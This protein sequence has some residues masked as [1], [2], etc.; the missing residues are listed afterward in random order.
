MHHS[1]N[2]VRVILCNRLSGY[3]FVAS[4]LVAILSPGEPGD[5]VL[6]LGVDVAVVGCGAVGS[7]IALAL[8]RAGLRVLVVTRRKAS[9]DKIVVEG[10]GSGSVPIAGWG[11]A[12]RFRPR[13]VLYAVKAYDLRGAV[14]N[15]VGAGWSPAAVVSLQNGLGSLE[16]L[17]EVFPGR[18]LLGIVYF[19][20]TLVAPC[21]ARLAGRGSVLLGWRREP[22][23]EAGKAC[24]FL[25]EALGA[26]GLESYCVGAEAERYRWLKLAVNTAINPVTVMAWSR[27]S[28]VLEDP[29][30]RELAEGL[31]AETGRVARAAGVNLPRDPVEETMRVARATRDN[32]SSMLQDVSRGRRTEVDY[33]N[34]AVAKRAWGLGVS[35]PLNW[36]AYRAVR[37]LEKWLA[38]RKSPCETLSAP[39]SAERK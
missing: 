36:F 32:C 6:V 11:E 33:I 19:G 18:A 16:L 9:V 20:S 3:S 13:L 24:G 28:V 26:G 39:S 7:V 14:E 21:R 38:G 30:A 27:N 1:S 35:A 15:S 17:E 12:R 8:M 23:P 31:A 29:F 2:R 4:R 37:L 5:P 34:G 10:L 22:L 25:A